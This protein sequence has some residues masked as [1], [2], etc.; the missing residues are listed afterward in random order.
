M[1]KTF[2]NFRIFENARDGTADFLCIL[3]QFDLI[4]SHSARLYSVVAKV[5]PTFEQAVLQF[6]PDD[7]KAELSAA[8]V[9]IE[10]KKMQ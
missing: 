3:Y 2:K 8:G 4:E 6:G 9:K 1:T 5:L 10:E 7:L